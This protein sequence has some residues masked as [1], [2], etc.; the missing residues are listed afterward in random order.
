[1]RRRQ[2]GFTLIELMIS[3]AIIGIL[4]A[5]AIPMFMGFMGKGKKVE[6]HLALDKLTKNI[7]VYHAEKRVLPPSTNLMPAISACLSGTDKTPQST[8]PM[9]YANAG[10]K[11][12][13]FHIDEPG[14]FQYEWTTTGVDG[15]A[16]ATGDLD[17][18]GTLGLLV[19]DVSISTGNVFETITTDITD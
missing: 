2:R 14:Y 18:D 9:W 3:V 15:V 10:W 12:L 13:E 17:C 16:K 8:Q 19:I 5:V 11:E 6:A 1:M 7:R 4:A